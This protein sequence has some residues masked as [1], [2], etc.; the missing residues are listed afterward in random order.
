MVAR[1]WSIGTTMAGCGS[2]RHALAA[3]APIPLMRVVAV[4]LH[5]RSFSRMS[6][7]AAGRRGCSK[8]PGAPAVSALSSRSTI[9]PLEQ[10][11]CD[12]PLPLLLPAR[13]SRMA[14]VA[15]RASRASQMCGGGVWS[16]GPSLLRERYG[17]CTRPWMHGWLAPADC[18]IDP[19]FRQT[20]FLTTVMDARYW[21]APALSYPQNPAEG[22]GMSH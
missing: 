20:F 6:G 15:S 2:F 9:G 13:R 18:L 21:C 11:R 22:C 10:P 14:A 17:R 4:E 16:A 8:W 7:G 5:T 3:G 12:L 1:S 19:D